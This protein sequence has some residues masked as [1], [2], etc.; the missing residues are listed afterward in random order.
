MSS[1]FPARALQQAQ[2]D[3]RIGGQGM[4]RNPFQRAQDF[5][6][7]KLNPAINPST[8]TSAQQ[9]DLDARNAKRVIDELQRAKNVKQLRQIGQTGSQLLGIGRNL[10]LG[11]SQMLVG[12]GSHL[13]LLAAMQ[14]SETI[15]SLKPKLQTPAKTKSVTNAFGTQYDMS[16]PAQVAALNRE[17]EEHK[18][19]RLQAINQ[20]IAESKVKPD[21]PVIPT[22][23]IAPT[24]GS[25]KLDPNA[26]EQFKTAFNA[27][28]NNMDQIQAMYADRPDLQE[29]A[30]HNPALAQKEYL[31]KA[32][33]A[34]G[35][36][37]ILDKTVEGFDKPD[38]PGTVELINGMQL[39][40][41][42]SINTTN[43]LLDN[44]SEADDSQEFLKNYIM[45]MKN[46]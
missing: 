21:T 17:I 23:P 31:K 9:T 25:A 18:R 41:S 38:A 22:A 35:T 44:M 36:P 42:I 24:T 45:S 32:F 4:E 13:P 33:N 14:T 43:Q 10:L 39:P 16:D 30:K 7:N 12:D 2:Y 15:N 46:K 3:A 28:N 6:R 29:W 19:G 40:Q 20:K 27:G 37:K 5:L 8:A 1:S 11:G 26:T 34:D